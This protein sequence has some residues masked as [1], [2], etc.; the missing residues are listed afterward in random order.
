[1]SLIQNTNGRSTEWEGLGL[2]VGELGRNIF[3]QGSL[4]AKGYWKAISTWEHSS[5]PYGETMSD[6]QLD[7]G[8][9]LEN[10]LWYTRRH[11]KTE[12][13]VLFNQKS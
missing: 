10:G 1:M 5:V 7:C 8:H 6:V 3:T 12:I 2:R 11:K 13:T 9:H 4:Q